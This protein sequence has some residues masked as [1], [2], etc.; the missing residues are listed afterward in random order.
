MD[1]LEFPTLIDMQS[2]SSMPILLSVF[3]KKNSKT[4]IRQKKKVELKMVIA[5]DDDMISQICHV[6]RAKSAMPINFGLLKCLWIPTWSGLTAKMMAKRT[7]TKRRDYGT[8]TKPKL[9]VVVCRHFFFFCICICMGILL[10]H[11]A[12]ILKA[13][14]ACCWRSRMAYLHLGNSQASV[15]SPLGYFSHSLLC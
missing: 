13:A 6:P 9:R 4:K 2:W 15:D 8:T 3:L 5:E 1:Y 11:T 10:Y 7:W 12:G 14:S